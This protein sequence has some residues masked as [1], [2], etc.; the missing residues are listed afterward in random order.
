MVIWRDTDLFFFIVPFIYQKF[1]NISSVLYA[2]R[3]ARRLSQYDL[4]VCTSGKH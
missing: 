1:G 2:E 3:D 4:Q